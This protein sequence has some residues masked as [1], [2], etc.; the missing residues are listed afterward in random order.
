MNESQIIA[1]LKTYAYAA[2]EVQLEMIREMAQR[3]YRLQARVTELEAWNSSLSEQIRSTYSKRGER[4][5]E[6]EAQLSEVRAEY[7]KV[8]VWLAQSNQLQ[9]EYKARVTEQ[10][11]EVKRLRELVYLAHDTDCTCEICAAMPHEPII[12]CICNKPIEGD[13]LDRR[14][15]LHKKDCKFSDGVDMCDCDLECHDECYDGHEHEYAPLFD[16]EEDE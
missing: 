15:W 7:Q 12:C 2:P 8:T 9:D 11:A 5:T 3:F 14:F 13:D 1:W 16:D 6:L 10:E 4:I